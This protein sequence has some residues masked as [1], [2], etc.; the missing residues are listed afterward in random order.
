MGRLALGTV[1]HHLAQFNYARARAV[2]DDPV[3]A[4]FVEGLD[5]VN[6]IA[7]VAPGFV[8]RLQSASGSATDIQAFEDPAL[9]LNY[10][11]WESVEA[12]KAFTT[13]VRTSSSSADADAGSSPSP[14][15]S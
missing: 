13:R 3:M 11:M 2:L 1:R 14:G 7:D 5:R 12:L 15:P 8:W 10:T 4:E 9:L 6:A